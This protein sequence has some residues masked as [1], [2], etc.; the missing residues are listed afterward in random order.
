MHHDERNSGVYGIDT[1]PPATLDDLSVQAGAAPG[2]ALVK[3]TEVGDDWWVGQ[4]PNGKI[5]L[6]WS[7][8]PITDAN[9]A[10]ANQVAPPATTAASGSLE[11]VTV[12]GLPANGQTIYFAERA[13]D[14][15]GN[16]SLIARTKLTKGDARPVAATKIR[17]SL[18]IAFKP[19]ASPDRTHGPPLGFGSCSPP[20][21]ASDQLTIGTPDAN[22][23]PSQSLGSMRYRVLPG[24]VRIAVSITDVRKQSDLSDY[25]GQLQ[26]DQTVRITDRRSGFDQDEP[27]TTMDASFPATVPCTATASTAIGSTCALKTTANAL[28]PGAVTTGART[29]WELGPAQVYDGGPDGVAA[30]QPNTLFE[31]QGVFVP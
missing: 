23:P 31:D 4:V 22:G 5:D 1:R 18:A 7:T 14:E 24:D 13:T 20:Q 25:S 6:R 10:A 27:G 17:S 30:T 19:C 3:W 11:Q 2:G 16:T 21:Q 8:A 15:S 9:F 29:V 28:V 12:T 26:A